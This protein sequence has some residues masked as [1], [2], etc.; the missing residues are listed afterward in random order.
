[1]VVTGVICFFRAGI[2]NRPG[3]L[4]SAQSEDDSKVPGG[5]HSDCFVHSCCKM[6][7]I[8]L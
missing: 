1:M 3:L 4:F 7:V 6:Q 2:R 5:W 8:I